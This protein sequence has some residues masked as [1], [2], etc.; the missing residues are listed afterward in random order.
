MRLDVF[1]CA[2]ALLVLSGAVRASEVTSS[3]DS[4]GTASACARTTAGVEGVAPSEP[5]GVGAGLV[6]DEHLLTDGAR[7]QDYNGGGELT[8][9]GLHAGPPAWLDRVLGFIDRSTCPGTRFSTPG[10]TSAHAFAVG[11]LIFTP[12]ELNAPGIVLGDRPYASEFFASAGRRYTSPTADVA[13][14]TSLTIGVLGLPA[15]ASVQRALHSLT[16]SVQPQGWSHQISAGGELTARYSVARQAFLG[17]YGAGTWHGDSK[18]TAAGSVGTV[19]E[20]SLAL[21][22][23][24]G[25]VQSPF[26][27]FAPEENTYVQETQPVPPPLG[28]DAPAE[29]FA[30]AGARAKLR[31]YNAY[32]QGQF[33]QSDLSY[34]EGSL[35]HVLGEAWAGVE[36]RTSSGWALN[37]LARWETPEMRWG[38]GSRSIVWG[39]VEIS[40]SFY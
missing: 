15:A 7:D 21:N 19:T 6:L 10:W 35:N 24:W 11:L 39:S 18:W 20:A 26:W 14:D 32:L 38:V 13:Y 27:A 40:K 5:T 36:L 31:V 25:R 29:I 8:F 23:R 9:S 34:N 4:A 16:G 37:Y 22:T 12:R 30:F 2:I 3:S 1:M 33:R 17:E 28:L